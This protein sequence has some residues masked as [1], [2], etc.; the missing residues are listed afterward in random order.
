M[1]YLGFLSIAGNQKEVAY[2]TISRL[3]L[4]VKESAILVHVLGHT[5]DNQNRVTFNLDLSKTQ[6]T[7]GSEATGELPM[8][9]FS[10]QIN[11]VT[12]SESPSAAPNTPKMNKPAQ[13][14]VPN[15]PIR[16]KVPSDREMRERLREISNGK[17]ANLLQK[18]REMMEEQN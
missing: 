18:I 10:E 12:S 5:V 11:A 1:N 17:S 4:S 14:G 16:S 13:R 2:K 8:P 7:E 9:S 6:D 3:V 15:G